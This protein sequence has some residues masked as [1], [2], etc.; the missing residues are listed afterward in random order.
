MNDFIIAQKTKITTFKNQY[1]IQKE[2]SNAT[3][4]IWITKTAKIK[5]KD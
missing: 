1:F 4:K 5:K 2:K 3:I